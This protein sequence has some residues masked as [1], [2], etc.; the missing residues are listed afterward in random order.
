MIPPSPFDERP[1][2]VAIAG[3]NGA[4]K[5][6]FYQ[7]QLK[8][9]GLRTVNPDELARDL[10]L[11]VYVSAKAAEA[12]RKALVRKKES[13]VFETVLSD[14]VGAKV[15]DLKAAVAEGYTVVLC[16][17]GISGPKV[18]QAR[19]AMRVTQGGHDVP[20]ELLESRYP[21]ILKNLKRAVR[22]LPHVIVYDNEDLRTPY[23]E[24]ARFESGKLV[25]RAE[26]IPKW[27][28]KIV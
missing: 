11:D 28:Q 2:I 25:S 18:S 13:F 6:T 1:I 5:T 21:R 27:A 3:P 7:S 10:G 9:A 15:E 19:V 26:T 14:P 12:L 17:I 16:F 22:V 24:V 4:G 8:K 23:R 20:S